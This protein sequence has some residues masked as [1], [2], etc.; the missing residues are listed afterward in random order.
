M[1]TRERTESRQRARRALRRRRLIVEALEDRRLLAV[2]FEFNYLDG[3]S[4]GFNDPSEGDRYR[5][6]LEA[7]GARLG[8]WLLDDATIQI[9]VAS[10]AFDGTGVGTA[11]SEPSGATGGGFFHNVIPGKIVGQGDANGAAA[12]GRIDIYFFDQSDPL[13]FV[14]DPAQAGGDDEIDFQ[15]VIIH[16]LVHAIGFTSNTTASG[17]DDSGDGITTPGNWTPYDQ[18]LSDV[19][20]N[21]LI[22]G[23]PESATAFRMDTSPT[24]WP[25]HSVGGKGPDAGLFFDG[26]IA[27]AVYGGRVPLFS[28]S[29][30]LSSSSV[31]HLDSEGFPDESS[32]FSPL[33]HLMSHA[34]ID[35]AVPQEL[36][37]LEKAI[38]ADIGIRVQED[39]SPI[40]VAPGDIIVEANSLGGFTGR[41]QQIDDFLNEVTTQDLFDPNPA[42]TVDLPDFLP[43]GPNLITFTATDDSG[44]IGQA[45]ALI[46]VIDS[47]A[48][49][50]SVTPSSATF[51][52][53]GPD[54]VSGV[55]LP[56]VATVTD[57]ADPS[58]TLTFNPGSDFPVGTTKATF[59]ARDAAL[60]ASRL[61]VDIIVQDTT[62][63]DFNLPASL[64]V[65]S[66]LADGADLTDPAIFDLILAG[67]SDLVDDDLSLTA[68]PSTIPF[69]TSTVTFTVTDDSG[70]AA[71]ATTEVTVD[72]VRFAVTTLDD[73][74][75]SD[76][77]SDPADLSLREAI[78]LANARPGADFIYFAASLTGSVLLD[79]A[80]GQLEIMDPLSI[81][82]PG[83]ET[84]TVDAQGNSRVFSLTDTAGDV[85][86]RGL[87]ISGGF[88]D[89]DDQSGAGVDS[90]SAG[91]LIFEQ[92]VVDGNRTTG[93]AGSGAGIYHAAGSLTLM[94]AVVSNN[95]SEGDS[96][97]GGGVWAGGGPITLARTSIHGNSTSGNHSPGGGLFLSQAVTTIIDSTIAENSTSAANSSGG[98]LHASLAP[99]SLVNSTVSGNTAG[100]ASEGG[101][102]F[103]DQSNLDIDNSTITANL[104]SGSG[105]GIGVNAGVPSLSL[106]IHTSIVAAN[107]DNGVAPDF[108]GNGVLVS[109]A[110]VEFSLIG[111]NAGTTLAE[112]QSADP[113]TG[114]I[115]GAADGAGL[116][117]PRLSPLADHG[118]ATRTHSLLDGSPAINAGDPDFE[119]SDFTPPLIHDQRGEGRVSG[120][121]I[122]M[123]SVEIIGIIQITWP[124][125]SDIVF[126]TA[127]S[128]QQLNATS[129]VPGTFVYDPPL[130]T[131]L[132]AGEAQTLRAT[133]TP[134]DQ[135]AYSTTTATAFINVL[136]ADP[137]INWPTPDR[138]V[139]GT[140]LDATQLNATSNVPGS[141]EYT[142][143]AGTLL[144]A[145][146]D[147]VLS[148]TF[149]P[150]DT[151]NFNS[152]TSSTLIN[153]D[154]ATPILTWEAPADVPF[155]TF[156]S[157]DQL[158]ATADVEGTF[159]YSPPAGLLLNVGP[160]QPLEVTFTP[161]S[162]NFVSVSRSVTITV[163]KA[164]PTIDW[165]DPT[166][167]VAGT[168]LSETQL[169][170]STHVPGAFSYNPPSGAF[171]TAGLGQTL[172]LTFTPD[173]D[174]QYN[175]IQRTV[176]IDVLPPQDYGD[177]PSGYPV[178]LAEDGARHGESTLRLGTLNDL[179]IDGAPS[180]AA[181]GD[182]AQDDGVIQLADLIVVNGATT[183][184]GFAV[185]ASEAG[186]L[187]AWIDFN[188]D[189]DWDDEGE[190]VFASVDVAA[191]I[192]HLPA[193]IPAGISAGNPVAR[194]RLSSA[195]GLAAT[196][197]AT[198][199]EVEDYLL[200]VREADAI[201]GVGVRHLDGSATISIESNEIVI[202]SDRAELFRAPTSALSQLNLFGGDNHDTVTFDLSTQLTLPSRGLDLRGGPSGNTIRFIGEGGA[203]D[204]TDPGLAITEFRN[205][206]LSGDDATTVALNAST[207]GILS[208][209]LD[210]LS[211]VGGREDTI[212]VT[213]AELWRLGE[214]IERDGQFFLT[215]NNM[216]VGGR[217][218]IEADL[219]RP[220]TNFLRAGDVNNDGEVSALDA[221]RIINEL[222][223][224]S[225]S[226]P[227]TRELVDP[228]TIVG[229]PA[230]YFDHNGDGRITAL[231][232]LRVI[233]DIARM[234]ELDV[235]EGE[236]SAIPLLDQDSPENSDEVDGNAP[237]R[238]FASSHERRTHVAGVES[239]GRDGSPSREGESVLP[240]ADSEPRTAV[241]ELLA[242]SKFMDHLI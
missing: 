238:L 40:V 26:P 183:V 109:A 231:D 65:D 239:A 130:G 69:G 28:P 171:L 149:T 31:S 138:I 241:D 136:K 131:I 59:T 180:A 98:G 176:Q 225:Y 218:S 2:S 230:A 227:E 111:D 181:D 22:D 197:E 86:F 172:T 73:E 133:F 66:N 72:D 3:N 94:D 145:G 122:D 234:N 137:E 190:Q 224:H 184:A 127:L 110:S 33:T 140:P 217:E 206:D 228:M 233:N 189:G 64:T 240:A 196:G 41:N 39:T 126:G 60:N 125:P 56:F 78:T 97:P 236:A 68:E 210:S 174:M 223:R 193:A 113:N 32:I 132:T 192:N 15:A 124:N 62:A 235:G 43:L 58:P 115:V 81:L 208:P 188:Q 104:A 219:A 11:S 75:D 18:F 220:W 185:E 229:W 200:T 79:A 157:S 84:I 112:S 45:T 24:G 139:Y 61:D 159:V 93:A 95:S 80:L 201:T 96:S 76:P 82:G 242:D 13:V 199:G 146:E 117:D 53:T 77:G 198:D 70:N 142:P 14:T 177:A 47:T 87:T 179:D 63:P 83:S 6:A 143:P 7:A 17:A 135:V 10:H 20:G 194:F 12:D 221:L 46:S 101:G 71:A 123:G 48:P 9:D 29:T 207:V 51:E 173:S 19:D 36:T 34:I 30:F 215:A 141:F 237:S 5:T 16:E 99:V 162:P 35:Q 23:N 105:G 214:P 88:L 116:I 186:K 175:T 103:A 222:G 120:R 166:P 153:V 167:I 25:Q 191:G 52:A 213:D 4:I 74:L 164:D 168:P 67:A 108:D 226:D 38:L 165:T 27:K 187:D 202:R 57:L 44:N 106:T 195:G 54:G 134:T 152:T 158:N 85:T 182:G 121:Q 154:Q 8:G 42:I 170:A 49:S 100:T 89:G 161:D 163:V 107:N 169:D 203:L 37:L 55:T 114:N 102:I 129:S 211:I 204:L 118:G 128:E 144:D 21:R 156:L 1:S 160:N 147:R 90:A 212:V 155:E 119:A 50:I 232:A 150:Q 209:T 148:V 178:M 205:L 91:A 216:V 151:V 92:T